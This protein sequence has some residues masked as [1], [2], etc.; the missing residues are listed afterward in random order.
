MQLYFEIKIKIKTKD[1]D[2][3]PDPDR[4]PELKI[5]GP[6]IYSH[7]QRYK[8]LRVPSGHS[9]LITSNLIINIM[10]SKLD[11]TKTQDLKKMEKNTYEAVVAYN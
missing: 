1:Y 6:S 11:Q 8:T 9:A 3:D 7:T 4:N 10:A 2:P 5:I